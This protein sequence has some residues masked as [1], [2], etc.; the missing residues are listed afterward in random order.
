MGHLET[1][2]R[3]ETLDR[4]L[5]ELTDQIKPE[6]TESIRSFIYL[7]YAMDS[8]KDLLGGDRR[9]L[10]GS[11]LSFWK[12]MEHHD[13]KQP[14]I[15]V[16]NPNHSLHGW[17]STHSIVRILHRDIPFLVDSVRMKLHDYQT[18]IHLVRNGT[19]L[20]P[21][22]ADNKRTLNTKDLALSSKE[23]FLHI[24]ID[25]IEN[26]DELAILQEQLIAVLADTVTVVDDYQAMVAK[27][28]TVMQAIKKAGE[29]EVQSFLNWLL[30]NRFTFLGFEELH[31]VN[32][33]N[34]R[35]VVKSSDSL[36]GLLRPKHLGSLG[37]ENLEPDIAKDFSEHKNCLSFSKAAVRSNV[38]RPAYPDFIAIRQFDATGNVILESRIVGLYTS[39]VYRES[40]SQI[41][42]IRNKIKAILQRANLDDKSH[43]GKELRQIL[44]IFPRNEL[45]QTD[46]VTL[47][48]TVMAILRIQERK[49]VKIFIRQDA[50][51]PFCSVLL[52]VPREMYSTSFRIRVEKI[53]WHRLQAVDSEFT[54]Y[55]SE[56]VLAR[57]HF[58]L[59]LKG[60]IEYNRNSINEEIAQAASTWED[61]F[62][63]II[64]EL[65][66]EAK[67]NRLI[68]IY[69]NGFSAGYR[70]GFTPQ[71]AAEDVSHFEKIN[72]EMPISM[73]FYREL[74]D[75]PSV[76]HFKLY[77]LVEPLPLADQ[78][79][80]IE[81]LG[82]RVLGETP[83][84]I[85]RNSGEVI[86]V[87]DFLL[88]LGDNQNVDIQKTLPVFRES[89]EKIWFGLAESDRFNR[90]VLAAGLDWRKVSML[91]TCARY[92]KQIKVG[93]SQGYIASTLNS[94][95]TITKMLVALFDTRFN[96]DLGLS[97][98]ERLAMQQ[99]IK[100]SIL[101]ALDDVSI[102]SQDFILRKIQSIIS[103]IL[104]TSFYQLNDNGEYK[105]YIAIK[106]S[107][108]D[109]EGIPK[110]V[111]LY[112]IFVY[113]P[114][115][116][117]VHLR[118]GKVA[119]GGLRWSDRIEDFRTEILG[120][121]KAQQVKNALI[122]PVGAKGGFVPKL[123]SPGDDRETI[124]TE[125][126]ACYKNFIRA[127]LDVTDNLVDGSVIHPKNVISYDDDDIY[128]VV[129]ADKGTATFS[130]IA[131]NIAEEYNFWLGDAFA[132]GGSVGYDH[133]KMGITAK[134]A[135]VSVQRHFREK[136]IN[137]QSD[138]ISVIGIGDMAG[139]VFG[140][141]TLLSES[142]ALIGAFNHIHIFIDPNPDPATSYIE[143]KRLF[144]LPRSS[145]ETY[146]TSV[147][148][149]GGG[150]F[151]RSAKSIPISTE[152]KER[153]KIQS[154]RLTPNEMIRALLRAQVDLLWNGGIGTYIKAVSESNADV[155]DKAS[156]PLRIN[157][158]ELRAR[159]V[160]EGGNL[161]LTQLG[162]I[163]YALQGGAINTDFIDNSGGV[164]CSDHEVNIKI[165][166]NEIV[167]NGDMTIKQR[168][169]LLEMMTEDVAKLVLTNN[170]RQT[171]AISLA[172]SDVHNKMEEYRRFMEYLEE[173]G[174]LDRAI[175][176]LPNPEELAAR[177]AA[178][179]VFTRP[180]LA[181]LVSYSKS[182]LKEALIKSDIMS[183]PYM[184]QELNTAFPKVLVDRFSSQV[185]NHRLRSEI[186]STQI[187]NRLIDMMG[188]TYVRR[189]HQTT[190]G[191]TAE[192]VRAFLISRD[193]FYIQQYW[194][195][196]E[197]LD[198]KITSELQVQIMAALV[199]LTRRASRWF[200][201]VK[202]QELV[203]LECI[204]HYCPRVQSF[205]ACFAD[206]LGKN[207][208]KIFS[209][210][211][212]K[213]IDSQV[214]E[215]LAVLVVGDRYLLNALPVIQASDQ[216]GKSLEKVARTYFALGQRLELEWYNNEL[217]AFDATNHWQSLATDSV[218][219]EA[220]WQQRELT[221]ALLNIP[222]PEENLEKQ[223][224]D[225]MM[226][227][228][229]LIA[230]WQ[231]MLSEIRSVEEPELAMFTVANRELLD[232]VQTTIHANQSMVDG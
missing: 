105:P 152:M 96:P 231:S 46:E 106:L 113:S 72:M 43:H 169:S 92:L 175:E 11:T 188:I 66:G 85:H 141:G 185:A 170:Y 147:I 153:F 226:S 201:R 99:H 219:D 51:G 39:P 49:Q 132:S 174:K 159:V 145:W 50:S 126:T 130:D 190:G 82:L 74:D 114:R 212:K 19:L 144:D 210:N 26:N 208:K 45:F 182:D 60:R 103:A 146:D 80:I 176:F 10:L 111:P 135:W 216:T 133:K 112:E 13:L 107:A 101:E 223:L 100:K 35:V 118:G 61:E 221:V 18:A 198:N 48:E 164:D 21:R 20:C 180:E 27:V 55:F 157:G 196:V 156:D 73:G 140:N 5:G 97:K 67:G 28:S 121:V 134:G 95:I 138:K 155:G 65:Y 23:A 76:I 228:R 150:V 58:I 136:G 53:L 125:G 149:P 14:K 86:W 202:R 127:L 116:E 193:V 184:I 88:S 148:S 34:K 225:W 62:S 129:A 84:L 90:L 151:P 195:Q 187:A 3:K 75:D 108:R 172:A 1:T 83:Y 139:D 128:L 217:S 64:L 57:V 81:N 191:T 209:S 16:F 25:R 171:Q 78:I 229:T 109:I 183:D 186:T 120:L 194:E 68:S 102:L 168:N 165:L 104:R 17:H 37:Q 119:R 204:S 15:E 218:R 7:F 205:I 44:E 214:P 8:R 32:K 12:F 87:H 42:Y 94:N 215:E 230:R 181:L 197:A 137:A 77:H 91:R 123:L 89:F 200:L 38:H 2:E 222:D 122:V 154:N 163:E 178:G 167:S 162:R 93:F 213:M 22:N 63:S 33:G 70:E 40:P 189:M 47:Y 207:E 29:T 143:R 69:G 179:H 124:H 24:E 142:I 4:L 206:Y 173:N 227:H 192:I 211:V 158:C 203:T 177:V 220:A 79:P 161:G 166:L 115:F 9:E 31:E 110:P 117:G 199:R 54:T 30:S 131:N 160:C 232:L 98:A 224:D 6:E 41:P 36:L 59:K 71:S 52:F 56:S